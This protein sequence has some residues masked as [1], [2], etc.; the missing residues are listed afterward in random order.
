[1]VEYYPFSLFLVASFCTRLLAYSVEELV[2]Y[3]LRK[4][5]R[6]I[7]SRSS[8]KGAGIYG[9][10]IILGIVMIYAW[11]LGWA[12]M[13][14][15]PLWLLQV[16]FMLTYRSVT[17]QGDGYVRYNRPTFLYLIF[18]LEIIIATMLLVSVH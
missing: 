12:S 13:L 6:D 18:V 11:K 4:T 9:Q 3:L 5:G 14:L 7:P 1:M 2:S 10:V 16:Y 17:L 15:Y 8:M